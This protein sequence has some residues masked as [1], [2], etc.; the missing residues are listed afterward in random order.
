VFIRAEVFAFPIPRDDGDVGDSGDLAALCLRP[1]ASDP[2]P[3]FFT[4]VENKG[5]TANRPL[6]DPGVTLGWPMG[7]AG[8]TQA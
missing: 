1:S 3:L 5:Q 8:V 6:G 4:F 2:T 7:G